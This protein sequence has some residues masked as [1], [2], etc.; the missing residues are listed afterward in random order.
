MLCLAEKAYLERAQTAISAIDDTMLAMVSI[1]IGENSARVSLKAVATVDHSST[2][3]RPKPKAR[4]SFMATHSNWVGLN[5][6]R[7]VYLSNFN[8]AN[9]T[10]IQYQNTI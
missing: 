9:W 2:A 1:W 7:L 4:R 5:T 6:E 8:T 3:E 10:F